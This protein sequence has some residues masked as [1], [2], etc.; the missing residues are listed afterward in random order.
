MTK[1][2]HISKNPQVTIHVKINPSGLYSAHL[3]HSTNGNGFVCH[4]EGEGAIKIEEALLD[5]LKAYSKGKN[6]KLPPYLLGN[7]PQ[8]TQTV[9]NQLIEIPFGKTITYQD[10]AESV[11]SVK[12]ARAAGGACGRNPLLLFVPCHRV[13]R[14]SGELGGFSEGLDYKKLLLDFEC[15]LS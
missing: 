14:S 3:S 9:L 10:L 5:W 7:L 12:G 4:I 15:A 6:I 11:G 2:F 1:I 13:I 8:F